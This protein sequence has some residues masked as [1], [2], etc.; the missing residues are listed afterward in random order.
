MTYT[1]HD[2][3]AKRGEKNGASRKS[4]AK[5]IVAA[6]QTLAFVIH[7]AS[8]NGNQF[9]F[10]ANFSFAD[11]TTN[12]VVECTAHSDDELQDCYDLTDQLQEAGCRCTSTTTGSSC[13]CE[14]KDE[15]P[16]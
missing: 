16:E 3:T 10:K 6:I 7:S 5:A 1:Q 8:K 11:S 13:E 15:S 12:Y 2:K 9:P 4:D 14:C